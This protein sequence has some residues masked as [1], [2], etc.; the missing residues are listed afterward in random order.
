MR[1]ETAES[2]TAGHP[3]KFCDLV[4]DLVLDECLK[5]DVASRVACETFATKALIVIGGEITSKAKIDYLS[6]VKIAA[7]RV[8]Y[9]LNNTD[10]RI[11]INEESSDI[12]DAVNQAEQGAGDQGIMV[13][14]ATNESDDFLPIV[15]SFAR[16]ITIRLDDLRK[17]GSL[18]GLGSDGKSQVSA[19]YARYVT[20]TIISG[21]LAE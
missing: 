7:E 12:N 3:N 21:G 8:S 4:S 15:V 16:K 1:I 14:Y 19:A 11:A 6:I 10:I 13:G 5:Q 18:K 20:K 17:L 9:S 2:V